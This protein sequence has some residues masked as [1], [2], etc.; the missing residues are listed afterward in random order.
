MTNILKIK[1]HT[2]TNDVEL[3]L[4]CFGRSHPFKHKCKTLYEAYWFADEVC[5]VNQYVVQHVESF[6]E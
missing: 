4:M 1:T 6:D 5:G 2:T 3:E